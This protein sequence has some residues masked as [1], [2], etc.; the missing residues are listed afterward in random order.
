MIT[1][2]PQIEQQI[3]KFASE[4]GVSTS[5]LITT[6]FLEY[7]SSKEAISRADASYAEYKATGQSVSLEQ[8]IKNNALDH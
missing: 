6:L 2:E 8:L 1:L 3:K 4:E 7:Q 5:E